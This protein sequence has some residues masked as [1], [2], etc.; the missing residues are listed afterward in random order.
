[1]CSH[2]FKSLRLPP[3][4]GWPLCDIF[5][6]NDHG[7]VPLVAS[8]FMSFSHAWRITGFVIILT[9]RVPLVEQELLTLPEHLRSLLV[10]IGIC[11]TRSLVLCVCFVDR[12]FCPFLLFLLT[13]VVSGLFRFMDSDYPFGIFKQV[14][15]TEHGTRGVTNPVISNEW[16]KDRIAIRTNRLYSWSFATHIL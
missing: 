16:G 15:I 2:H 11:V 6:T 8:T 14:L 5:V 13:I 4:L 12:F 1:M 9:Q 3:W 7:Y 10:F